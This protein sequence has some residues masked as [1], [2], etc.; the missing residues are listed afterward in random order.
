MAEPSTCMV[1]FPVRDQADLL[2]GLQRVREQGLLAGTDDVERSMVITMISELATN[3]MKYARSGMM[4]VGRSAQGDAVDIEVWADDHGP[5][6]ADVTKAMQDHFTTGHTLGLGLPGVRRMADHFQIQC[7]PGAGTHVHARRRVI[8]RRTETRDGTTPLAV[9]RPRPA[10]RTTRQW[11]IGLGTRTMPGEMVCGDLA[12]ALELGDGL[13]LAM[14][15]GT[16]HGVGGS[17]AAQRMER[18]LKDSATSDL[19][20]LL[21]GA[22]EALQGSV[23]AAVGLLFVSPDRRHAR[24][25]GVGNTSIARRAGMPWRPLSRDG[26]LGQR[27]PSLPDQGTELDRGDLIVMWTDGVGGMPE[28]IT[29]RDAFRPAQELADTLLHRHGKPHDDAGCVV[30][31]WNP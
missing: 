20:R 24:Y 25:A 9:P 17:T 15:D 5:G 16:G 31:R 12:L 10:T 8:G 30:L 7:P 11:D 22:H 6:I 18:H 1:S 4:R 3:I 21:L 14:V 26:I 23:G 13:L 19:P 27:M 2:V 28:A 29:A